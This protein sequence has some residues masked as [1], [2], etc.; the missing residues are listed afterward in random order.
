MAHILKKV[1]VNNILLFVF[2]KL[3]IKTA[4]NANQDNLSID[5]DNFLFYNCLKIKAR[6]IEFL[7]F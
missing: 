5:K 7:L 1:N 2:F 4:K 3:F 6:L